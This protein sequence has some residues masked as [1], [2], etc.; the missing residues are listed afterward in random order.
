ME[1]KVK[2]RFMTKHF[3]D[4]QYFVELDEFILSFDD[5]V[6]LVNSNVAVIDHIYD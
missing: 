5:A 3:Y 2:I 1:R 6:D 4:N